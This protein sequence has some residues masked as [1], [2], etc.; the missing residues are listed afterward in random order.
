MIPPFFGS[1]IIDIPTEELFKV[2]SKKVLFE[3]RWGFS[4]GKLSDDEYK[5]II[6]TKAEPALE[7]LISQEVENP[8]IA[9]KAVYGFYHCHSQG[10]SIII[11]QPTTTKTFTF[12]RKTAVT[13]FHKEGQGGFY[14]SQLVSNDSEKLELVMSSTPFYKGGQGGFY[15][16]KPILKHQYSCISDF[17]S[18]SGDYL[19][20]FATTIGGKIIE[21][22]KQLFEANSYFDY[23]LLHGLGAEMADC[24]AV[25]THRT[26]CE[27]LLE[28]K[29]AQSDKPFGCRYS[30]GYPACPDLSYQKELF[31]ILEPSRIGLSLTESYQM[32]PE[33]S[34]SGFILFNPEACYIV[35]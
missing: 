12:P 6:E 18:P 25:V 1:K 26:I 28:K 9:C 19:A 29:L 15:S 23:H 11:D 24:G 20:F 16:S 31:D 32:V 30:F 21:A 3:G 33:L 2:L 22:E 34:V 27:E 4:K 13:P 14:S 8:R 5:K 10:D 17:I 7:K 35:P